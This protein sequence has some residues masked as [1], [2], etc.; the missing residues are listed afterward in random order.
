MMTDPD[1]PFYVNG[2]ENFKFMNNGTDLRWADDVISILA[3]LEYKVPQ[4]DG[5]YKVI[6]K[7]LVQNDDTWLTVCNKAVQ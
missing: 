1:S 6:K 2:K 7:F 4:A 3:H 5:T